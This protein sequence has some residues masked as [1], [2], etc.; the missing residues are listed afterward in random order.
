[1]SLIELA[2]RC[3]LRAIEYAEAAFE[4][5]RWDREER[6]KFQTADSLFQLAAALKARASSNKGGE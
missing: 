3:E 6:E 5:H 4:D 1:M 2:E